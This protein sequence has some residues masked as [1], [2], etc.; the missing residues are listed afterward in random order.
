MASLV[1]FW[2]GIKMCVSLHL[3]AVVLCL[4]RSRSCLV[5]DL[6]AL[7]RMMKMVSLMKSLG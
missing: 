1:I 7:T 3:F 6:E 5:I 4:C 2:T